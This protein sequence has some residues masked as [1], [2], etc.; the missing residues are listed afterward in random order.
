METILS[1]KNI[2]KEFGKTTALKGV[3][4]DVQPGEIFGFLGPSGAGKTTTVKLFT[5]QLLQSSGELTIMG[6]NVMKH[7]NEVL[8]RKSVV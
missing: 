4:F 7:R 1:M 2:Y 3:S 8:D 6:K 5:A